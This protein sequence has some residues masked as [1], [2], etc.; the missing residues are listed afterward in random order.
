VLSPQISWSI[1]DKDGNEVLSGGAPVT[2][3]DG[4]APSLCQTCKAAGGSNVTVRNKKWLPQLAECFAFLL[5]VNCS[6]SILLGFVFSLHVR[7]RCWS[8]MLTSKTAASGMTRKQILSLRCVALT[9]VTL[10]QSL[11]SVSLLFNSAHTL[12]LCLLSFGYFRWR[13][14]LTA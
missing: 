7:Y 5:P 6:H 1:E 3:A 8:T 13:S 14:T 2:I 12:T 4:D 9:F 10:C 11:F